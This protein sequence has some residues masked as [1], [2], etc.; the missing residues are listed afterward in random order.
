MIL[1]S[2]LY[3]LLYFTRTNGEDRNLTLQVMFCSSCNIW[4]IL[5]IEAVKGENWI[6][7]TINKSGGGD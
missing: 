3:Y 7:E 2:V 4:Q 5:N 1:L 6:L